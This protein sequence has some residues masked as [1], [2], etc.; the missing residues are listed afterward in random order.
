MRGRHVGSVRALRIRL[1]SPRL[2]LMEDLA[3]PDGEAGHAR[4]V[5][6][7]PALEQVR[8]FLHA[9]HIEK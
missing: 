4:Q 3:Q 1:A 8:V 5:H 2:Q 9:L 6:Q 7:P